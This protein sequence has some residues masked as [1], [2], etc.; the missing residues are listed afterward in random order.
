MVMVKMKGKLNFLM[1]LSINQTLR[2]YKIHTY[3]YTYE[4]MDMGCQ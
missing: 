3:T 4:H 1:L 2:M